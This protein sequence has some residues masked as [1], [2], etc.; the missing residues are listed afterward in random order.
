MFGQEFFPTPSHVI[1]MMCEGVKMDRKTILEPSAGKGDIVDYL[2]NHGAEVVV[3]ETNKDLQSILKTKCNIIEDDFF[4]LTSEKISHVSAIVMNP[5]F[6]NADKHILHAFNIAPAGCNI[7]ALCNIETVNNTRYSSRE[8]LHTI[9]ENFGQWQDIGNVFNEAERRTNVNVALITIHK[10]GESTESEFEGFFTE[11]EAEQEQFNG[12][13]PYNFVRDLVN[14]YIGAIKI[15]DEQLTAAVKMN[16]L[17]SSFYSSSL[18]FHCTEGEKPKHRN[19]FK[20]DLQKNAW[21]FIFNKMNMQKYATRGLKEDINKFV[22]QQQHIPFTMKNI[23]R[24]LEIVIGTQEQRMDKSL[25]E[26]F[27]KVTQHS[28]DNKYN[29][30]GWKTNS[31]YL[32]T[33]KFIIPHVFK[34][35]YRGEVQTNY[36]GWEEPVNDIVKALCYITGFNYDDVT[37]KT[38]YDF[39]HTIKMEFGQWHSWGF[40]EVKAYKKGTAHFKFQNKDHWAQFNQRIAKLKGYPLFEAK[41]QTAYQDRQTGRKKQEKAPMARP[42]QKAKVLFEVTI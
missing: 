35:G 3:C 13:M 23:Y 20:K 41:Q 11:E 38:L 27:D 33:E 7:V 37:Y 34:S 4:K 2:L 36:N 25:L 5:P 16:S 12:L 31:H 9:I 15:Y 32:L 22:E 24:M 6:S 28:S 10:P 8:E 14:R 1:E 18:A 17:T 40:F 21:N 29:V 42:T 39:C 19:E 26:V 30:E